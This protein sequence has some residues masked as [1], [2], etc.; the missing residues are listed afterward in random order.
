MLKSKGKTVDEPSPVK[1]LSL[2][3]WSKMGLKVYLFP[4]LP[5]LSV[6]FI[7]MDI[8]FKVTEGTYGLRHCIYCIYDKILWDNYFLLKRSFQCSQILCG[9]FWPAY[10]FVPWDVTVRSYH[11]LNMALDLQKSFGL[12]VHRRTH[13]LRPRNSPPPPAFGLIHEGAIGEPR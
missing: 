10:K 5:P 2:Y 4:F 11:G 3:H 7:L 12:H 13:W 6:I 9:Q 1:Q 8:A